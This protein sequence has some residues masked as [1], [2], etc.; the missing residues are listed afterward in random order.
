[1][2][3]RVFATSLLVAVVA[4]GMAGLANA[5]LAQLDSSAFAWKYEMD[6]MPDTQDKDGNST[7]DFNFVAG[8]GSATTDGSVLRIINGK[9]NGAAFF[10]SGNAGQLWPAQGFSYANGYT[11]E[12][13]LKIISQD[14]GADAVFSLVAIPSGTSNFAA[15]G[16]G[17]T[18]SEWA[19]T[20]WTQTNTDAFH[21]FRVAQS[22]GAAS[23][24]VWR[25]GVVLSTEL[26]AAL[27]YSQGPQ[28]YFGDGAST[29]GGTVDVD[30]LRLTT[31]AY[32]PTPEPSTMVLLAMGLVGL[33][34][35]AWR[36]RKC[37][38]S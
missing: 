8:D 25:D 30:Y 23:Y 28:L 35:Y 22:P 12:A 26:G 29:Y 24:T 20:S 34:A 10:N 32:A 38:L 3:C 19:G 13:K 17:S 14:T 2:F 11:L 9:A 5:D 36:K 6:A 37:V 31:G 33:L 16:V 27:V 21:V 4:F 1:M 15:L 7:L 18:K